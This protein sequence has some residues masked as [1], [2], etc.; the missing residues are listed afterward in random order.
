[1]PGL[2]A[3]IA[4]GIAIS[5]VVVCIGVYVYNKFFKKQGFTNLD[6]KSRYKYKRKSLYY[7]TSK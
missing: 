3:G 4:I 5:I 2:G 6:D 1:M 7:K